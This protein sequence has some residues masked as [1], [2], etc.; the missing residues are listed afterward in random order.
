MKK[1]HGILIAGG[2]VVLVAV[3]VL[4]LSQLNR[5]EPPE[6][7]ASTPEQTVEY[8]ASEQFAKADRDDRRQY[9][10]KM[11]VADSNTPVLSLLFNPNVSEQQRQK[12]IE[13]IL[14]VVAPAIN[15]RLDEFERLPFAERTARLDA[16]IDQIQ[17][18]RQNH[19]SGLSSAQRLNL[20][21]QYVDPYT[22]ARLRKHLPALR[23]RMK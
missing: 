18:F 23:D 6:P 20:I 12:V 13:N 5:P 19:P 9:V 22:R 4:A 16:I 11:R 3:C 14:P 8:L 21:L 15:Q 7:Q 17:A 1:K 2:A 10:R